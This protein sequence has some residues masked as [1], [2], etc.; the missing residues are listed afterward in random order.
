[1]Q[2][3]ITMATLIRMAQ[4]AGWRRE[5]RK[6]EALRAKRRL[7]PIAW[8]ELHLL[9]KR[10]FLIKR[11]LD[12]TAMSVV[13]GESN[14]G[15]TFFALDIALHISLGR[16]WNGLKTRQGAVVYIAAEGGMGLEDRLKAFLMHYKTQSCAEFYLIPTGIDL[17]NSEEDCEELISE[18]QAIPN[19]QLII[20]DTLSRAMSGGN[21]NSPD[22]M[23]AFIKNCDRLREEIKA[24]VMI[25]HH[26]GKDSAKGARGHSALKAAVDTEIE[27]K[28][29][30][31][32]SI[33]AEITKQRD[34]KTGIKY[35]FILNSVP[36][37][38]DEDGELKS[39]CVLMPSDVALTKKKVLTGQKKRAFEVLRNLLSEKGQSRCL[40]T[41]VPEVFCIPLADFRDA[42]KK[43]SLTAS[44]KPDNVRR[45]ISQVISGLNDEGITNIYGEFI[46]IPD[47]AGYPG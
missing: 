46:W 3:H 29:G 15:K 12:T 37:G 26:S 14:C 18:V 22:D 13:Y 30:E 27:V 40:Q 38:E 34:G 42:L 32:L 44:D 1:M 31:D 7:K 25:I 28:K 6:P 39:S 33:V 5:Q 4:E 43:A 45:G 16:A 8:T 10:E 9:P 24:H 19:V 2:E 17:C 11:L 20:V 23:G 47:K 35:G 36:V 41:G 21:E